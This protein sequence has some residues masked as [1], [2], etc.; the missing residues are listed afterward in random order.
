MFHYYY[1]YW[2]H[3]L[4]SPNNIKVIKTKRIVCAGHV[5]LMEEKRNAYRILMKKTGKG[6]LEDLG[7]DGYNIKNNLP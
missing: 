2:L 7:I 6:H 5:V 4:Y 1:Y 3:D